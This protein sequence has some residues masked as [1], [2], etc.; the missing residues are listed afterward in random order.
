M[1]GTIGPS[2]S[3]KGAQTVRNRV[4]Q[5][6]KN[7]VLALLVFAS[8]GC[9]QSAP[10]VGTFKGVA[11]VGEL[12]TTDETLARAIRR[13]ELTLDAKGD[14]SLM[15]LG[16]PWSGE[17]FV[18]G[19]DL[20]LKPKYVAERAIESQ[21]DQLKTVAGAIK[22]SIKSPETLLLTA[23]GITNPVNLNRLSQP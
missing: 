17:A 6:T 18:T 16:L 12:N 20:I 8:F 3:A 14:F 9:E 22:V 21:P 4:A 7:L 1:I 2:I 19:T 5:G 11:E 15:L 13:V 23:P 10:L